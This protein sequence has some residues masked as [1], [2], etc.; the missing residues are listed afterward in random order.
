MVDLHCHILPGID[1]GA[2]TMSDSIAMAK[3]AVEQGIDTII[4]TPH[5][6]NGKYDNQK[7]TILEKVDELQKKLS[8]EKIDLKILPGQEVR[9][10]GELIDG[11]EHGEVQ[12]LAGS[13]YV[14]VEFP[15]ASVPRYTE[16]LFFDM[17]MKGLTP[18]IAHPE[19]NQQI[20]EQPNLLYQL[21]NNGA[22]SQVTA[23]S[24][25][26]GFGKKI[27]NF[28]L[29]L[30]EANLTHF[31][32]SDAHNLHNRNFKMTE[33]FDLIHSIYDQDFVDLLKE[34]PALL[35]EGKNVYKEIP[36]RIKKKKRFILF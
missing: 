7:P 9:I 15:S 11:F 34:N 16:Q 24:V 18:I 23:A 17:Q 14:L 3:K 25:I 20:I 22:L 35:A 5:Y 10:H 4:V 28:T 19:R 27:K 1:D 8:E 36:E 2:Q 29:Q 12:T 33:A 26:G 13:S 32:A 21:I 31:I 6:K 30:I